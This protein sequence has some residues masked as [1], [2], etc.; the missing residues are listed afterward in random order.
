MGPVSTIVLDRPWHHVVDGRL[1]AS[2]DGAT[3]DTIDPSTEEPIA[4]VARGGPAEVDE[5][6]AAAGRAMLGPWS[7]L[8]PQERGAL[9]FRLSDLVLA[10]KHE[11]AY[12]E[13]RDVGKPFSGSLGDIDGV[14]ATLRYNAGAADK[15]GG[16]VIPLGRGYVDFTEL[17]PVGVTAHIVPWN[18]PLGMAIRSLAPAL[19]AGCTAIV[20]PAEQAPLS[21]LRF[22]E[23]VAEAGIPPGVVNAVC[24]Y[25]HEVGRPLVA[26]KDVKAVHFTGSVET[27][28]QVAIEA[29]RGLKSC[30]LE[31]GGKN[32]MVVCCDADLDRAVDDAILGA[33]DNA[34][35]VCSAASRLIV[36]RD[37]VA[38]FTD[39]F[40]ARAATLTVGPG[41]DDRDMGPLVSQEQQEKVLDH[42]AGARRD[43]ARLLLG[44]G[45]P[46]GLN[47]GFFVAPTIFAG[48]EPHWTI[49][50]SEVFGPVATIASF[51]DDDEAVA[52]ANGVTTGLA[53]GVHTTDVSRALSFAR[54]LD[55]GSVWINGWFMGGVQAPTGGVKDSGLGRE[56]GLAGIR[57]FLRI[58]NVAVR[59]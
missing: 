12:L 51:T 14:V 50:Q 30:V 10:H 31:L 25:G 39:R 24:G 42:L 29:A 20:K 40:L 21:T 34:G 44:G 36:Q 35:Q 17:E 47:R 32:A 48:V 57:N 19:A 45:R 13:T 23:L 5:A 8:T 3:F 22:M 52:M 59:L 11:L 43:G 16:D 53:G 9:L 56:R 41:L 49:A 2:A 26:H 15:I 7:A 54:R 27:G 46:E 18:F 28:R 1:H 55:V 6:V 33:F 4:R 37:V 38:A 58:K